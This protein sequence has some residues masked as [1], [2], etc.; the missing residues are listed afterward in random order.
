MSH[1]VE[2]Q[3]QILNPDRELL[4]EA[5]SLVAKQHTGGKIQ[6][7]YSTYEREKRQTPLAIRT[8][9]MYRGMAIVVQDGQLTFIGDGYGY[10]MHYA[11]VQRQIVQTYVSLATMQALQALGYQTSVEDGEAGNIVIAGVTYA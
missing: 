6:N 1:I 8:R 7:F 11:E 9:L 4:R 2:A 10:E 3:T 5:V